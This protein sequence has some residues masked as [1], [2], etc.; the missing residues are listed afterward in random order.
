MKNRTIEL[1]AK[2]SGKPL[3]EVRRT[4]AD[5]RQREIARFR[6]E[7]EGRRAWLRLAYA[8]RQAIIAK[9]NQR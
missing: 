3:T 7:A 8:L 2:L 4:Y 5:M 9:L 1:L 6:D